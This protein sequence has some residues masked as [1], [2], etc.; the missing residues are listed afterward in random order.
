MQPRTDL[1]LGGTNDVLLLAAWQ[2]ANETVMQ[3]TR[4]FNTSDGRDHVISNNS[5]LFL[6]WG[7]APSDGVLIGASYQYAKHSACGF[8]PVLLLPSAAAAAGG[9]GGAS[10]SPTTPQTGIAAA[11]SSALWETLGRV[12]QFQSRDGAFKVWWTI[13]NTAVLSTNSSS[14]SSSSSS[15]SAE[16]LH[17]RRRTLEGNADSNA[18]GEDDEDEEN[19]WF[20]MVVEGATTGWVSVGLSDLPFMA[21][22]DDM[23]A[24]VGDSD[25][26]VTCLDSWSPDQNQT[27]TDKE[28]NGT[29]DFFGIQAMQYNGKTA[30]MFSRKLRTGDAWDYQIYP[31]TPFYILYALGASDGYETTYGKHY[32]TGSAQINFAVTNGSALYVPTRRTTTTT[33]TT[34]TTRLI[35]T[36]TTNQSDLSITPG[37]SLVVTTDRAVT[38][39]A[40]AATT[41]TTTRV[42]TTPTTESSSIQLTAMQPNFVSPDQDFKA[43]WRVE[44]DNITIAMWASTQGWLS[45]GFNPN[46]LMTNADV[47]VGWIDSTGRTKLLDSWSPDY[48]QP[49]LDSA[50]GGQSSSSLTSSD[51]DDSGTTITFTRALDT[52]DSKDYVLNSTNALFLVWGYCNTIGYGTTYA[53]H[54]NYGTSADVAGP[55]VFVEAPTIAGQTTTARTTTTANTDGLIAQ[56]SRVPIVTAGNFK[57]WWNIEGSV[58]NFVMQGKCICVYVCTYVRMHVFQNKH[59]VF[60]CRDISLGIAEKPPNLLILVFHPTATTRGWISIGFSDTAKMSPADDIVGWIGYDGSVNVLDTWSPNYD[61]VSRNI[62]AVCVCVCV[63]VCLFHNQIS[64]LTLLSLTH[65][66]A[67]TLTL[68]FAAFLSQSLSF[69]VPSSSLPHSPPQF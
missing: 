14:S 23:V 56:A 36:P 30:I 19:T 8:V 45:V 64:I 28:L 51:Q 48:L 59:F 25:G 39:A 38:S 46:P 63:C 32:A 22:S 54:T 58:I 3:F 33:T 49:S 6:V 11:N 1:Q 43:W 27:L 55:I 42:E 2:T 69:S 9:D 47:Y 50:V 44:G 17:H 26:R 20:T 16:D 35:A 13:N 52:R 12:P 65:S 10:S 24:W 68:L 66:L 31:A 34:T 41:T 67:H 4:K 40:T 7:Y 53:E 5:T 21:R 29:A 15:T 61:Q 37:A 18:E 60:F 57:V 62:F